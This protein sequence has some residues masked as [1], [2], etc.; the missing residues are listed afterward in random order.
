[1]ERETYENERKEESELGVK[2]ELSVKNRLS[3]QGEKYEEQLCIEV[4]DHVI[5]DDEYIHDLMN[6]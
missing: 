6:E 3:E 4:D 1:M 5:K 2:T